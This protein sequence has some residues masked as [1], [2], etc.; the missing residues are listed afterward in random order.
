MEGFAL[1]SMLTTHVPNTLKLTAK[2][3]RDINPDLKALE[4][5]RRYLLR[6][7]GDHAH[8]VSVEIVEPSSTGKA[9][10]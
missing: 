7:E 8:L 2:E 9:R 10:P 1:V 4:G 6:Q 5:G 3:W